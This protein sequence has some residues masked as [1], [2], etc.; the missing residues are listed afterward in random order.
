V[1][2][3][4]ITSCDKCPVKIDGFCNGVDAEDAPICS[5]WSPD[6]DVSKVLLDLLLDEM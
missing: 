3:S 1:L 4:D 2:Y 6:T 5:G